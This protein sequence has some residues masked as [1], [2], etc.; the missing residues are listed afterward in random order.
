MI[1]F[2]QYKQMTIDGVILLANKHH[3]DIDAVLMRNGKKYKIRALCLYL[4]SGEEEQYI[5]H[6]NSDDVQ[7]LWNVIYS[8]YNSL[9]H[10]ELLEKS[11]VVNR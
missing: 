11:I 1:N 10:I 5:G 9:K 7:T 6:L 2:E 4:V 3:L 8:C